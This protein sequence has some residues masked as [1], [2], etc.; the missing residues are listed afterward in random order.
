MSAP[1]LPEEFDDLEFRVVEEHWNDY[2]MSDG[3]RMIAR[4]V[5]IK[6]MRPR[7]PRPQPPQPQRQLGIATQDLFIVT[8]AGG[9]RGPPSPLRPEEIS[10]QVPVDRVP[11]RI[12]RSNERWNIYE[13]PGTGDLIRIRLMVTDVFRVPNRFDRFGYP[14]L[15]II[16]ALVTNIRRGAGAPLTA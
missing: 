4:P 8:A 14:A 12:E 6:V 3:F 11:L 5:L 10:G 15:I 2:E 1:R 9:P 16:S 7:S 13:V